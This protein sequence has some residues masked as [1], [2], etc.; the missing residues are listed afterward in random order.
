MIIADPDVAEEQIAPQDAQG[1]AAY[2]KGAT[3]WLRPAGSPGQE[4]KPKAR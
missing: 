3:R 2:S 4:K 1:S